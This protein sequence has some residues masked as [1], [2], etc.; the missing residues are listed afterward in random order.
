MASP[1]QW[2][3]KNLGVELFY[4]DDSSLL[5]LFLAMLATTIFFHPFSDFVYH[6]ASIQRRYLSPSPVVGSVSLFLHV[7]LVRFAIVGRIIISSFEKPRQNACRTAQS[8]FLHGR[9]YST[10][11]YNQPHTCE[12]NFLPFCIVYIYIF[13]YL[14]RGRPLTTGLYYPFFTIS[15][16]FFF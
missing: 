2:H 15:A 13:I 8:F 4:H 1:D 11:A 16:I 6:G 5:F 14:L 10:A 12:S 7:T 3:L 9:I